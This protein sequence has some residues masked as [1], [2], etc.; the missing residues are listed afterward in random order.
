MKVKM[1]RIRELKIKGAWE[2][3][4]QQ[5]DDRRGVFLVWYDEAT[6]SKTVGHGLRLG[7]VNH[8]ISRKGT[9]RGI[10]F[11]QVP[12]G[13]AKY[14]YC[15]Q[16]AVLDFVVDIRTGSPTFGKWDVVMLD[17]SSHRTVYLAEGL[18]HAYVAL[19]ENSILNYLCSQ[20]YNPA[21]EYGID[22]FDADIALPWPDGLPR[23]L[24]DRDQNAP[25]FAEVQRKGL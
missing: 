15:P 22:P 13:Q 8:A 16:G 14:V 1:V 18:G 17:A 21:R 4:P 3:I 24:S 23:V 19:E 25:S 11:A 7:Q 20:C 5:H 6:F 12:P 9:I 2:F 10:H